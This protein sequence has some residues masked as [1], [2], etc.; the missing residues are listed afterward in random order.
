MTWIQVYVT[1]QL[2]IILP[3][4]EKPEI[5]AVEIGNSINLFLIL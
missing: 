5:L 2:G 4:W 1:E 3:I